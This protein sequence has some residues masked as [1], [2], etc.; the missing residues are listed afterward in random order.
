MRTNARFDRLMNTL[1][2]LELP[3]FMLYVEP[4]QTIRFAKLNQFHVRQNGIKSE[5]LEGKTPHEVFPE[6][7]ADTITQ[8]YTRCLNARDVH[9]YE[10]LLNINNRESWWKTTLAPIFEGL[11]IIGIVGIAT[12]ITDAKE[13]EQELADAILEVSRTNSDL[14]VLQSATAHDLR[15]PLRQASIIFDMILDDFKDLGDNKMDLL[16]KGREVMQKALTQIDDTLAQTIKAVELK[17]APEP[18]DLDHWF[19]DMVAIFDPLHEKTFKHPVFSVMC[20]KFILDIGLRNLLDNAFRY[21]ESEIVVDVAQE[22]EMLSFSVS[23]NG[24][25]ADPEKL[26]RPVGSKRKVR[27]ADVSGHGLVN[28]RSLVEARGGQLWLGEP[29]EGET[30]TVVCFSIPGEIVRQSQ[31]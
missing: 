3:A 15:G 12:E 6:R 26:M 31:T 23:N 28:V 14:R 21:A 18:V 24:K 9:S 27:K 1:D 30:G 22:G 29:R 10:E 11:D 17:I 19:H 5:S 8:S 25:P 4:D 7:M 2:D 13:T 20:E 16:V